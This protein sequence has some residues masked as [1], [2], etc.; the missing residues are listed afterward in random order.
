MLDYEKSISVVIE[1]YKSLAFMLLIIIGFN[2]GT[3]P[4][5][6]PE[7]PIFKGIPKARFLQPITAKIKS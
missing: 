2:H 6:Y 5:T 7:V 4:F 1:H 3:L